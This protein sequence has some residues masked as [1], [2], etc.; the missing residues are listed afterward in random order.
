MHEW[1]PTLFFWILYTLASLLCNRAVALKEEYC[2]YF[3]LSHSSYSF[4]HSVNALTFKRNRYPGY[5]NKTIG[6]RLANGM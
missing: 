3:E 1:N 4:K 2:R 5:N 6:Q